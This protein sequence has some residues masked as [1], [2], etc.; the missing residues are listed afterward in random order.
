MTAAN[1][2]SGVAHDTR[3]VNVRGVRL[4][5]AGLGVI[6]VA[7]G[8]IVWGLYAYLRH[9]EPA[10][11]PSEYPLAAERPLQPP[12]PRLQTNPRADLQALRAEEE[13]LLDTYG[14]VDRAAGVVR[15][16]I[17]RAMALTVERGLPA[18]EESEVQN[19]Q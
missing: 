1:A 15:I 2:E 12:E 19:V 8:L 3:D 7:L 9:V 17:D 5:G 16:P 13:A 4:F 6:L 14:W 18:R 11:V 10:A